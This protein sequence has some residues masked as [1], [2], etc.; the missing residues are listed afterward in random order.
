MCR[1]AKG[2]WSDGGPS[3][4]KHLIFTRAAKQFSRFLYRQ[5]NIRK[6]E[7]NKERKKEVAV[8]IGKEE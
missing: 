1:G 5:R 4:R 6:K 3:S 2:H 8:K 7:K